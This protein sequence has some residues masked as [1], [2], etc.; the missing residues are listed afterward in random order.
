MRP[1]PAPRRARWSRA[2]SR[3]RPGRTSTPSE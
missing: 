2:R 3:P 1:P